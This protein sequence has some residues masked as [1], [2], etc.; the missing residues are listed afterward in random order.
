MPQKKKERG[1]P[2][3]PL[4]PRIDATPEE[5]ARVVLNA[6]RPKGP[7]KAHDYFC[8]DCNRQVAFP[9]TLY[10]DHRCESCHQAAAV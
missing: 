10:N 3:R 9:D 8:R 7:V 1:R 5:I 4:P 6:G 2:N